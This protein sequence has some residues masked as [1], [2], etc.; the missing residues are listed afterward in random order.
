MAT[1]KFVVG[2]AALVAVIALAPGAPAPGGTLLGVL[3]EEDPAATATRSASNGGPDGSVDAAAIPLAVPA[4]SP[5]TTYQ[6][7]SGV[8][9]QPRTSALTYA[10]AGG[11]ALAV[12]ATASASSLFTLKVELPQGATLTQVIWY[13]TDDNASAS[14][15]MYTS[16][17]LPSD[18]ALTDVTSSFTSFAGASPTRQAITATPASAVV[19]DNTAATYLLQVGLGSTTGMTLWGARV[20][21]TT[22]APSFYP[23]T[24]TRVYDSRFG[25]GALALSQSRTISIANAISLSTGAVTVPNFVPAGARA[26]SYNLTITQTVGFGY[27]Q[28]YPAGG[29]PAASAINWTVPNLDLANGGVLSVSTNRQVTVQAGGGTGSQTHFIIDVTGYFL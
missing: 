23:L 11:G 27:L 7:Y 12:V 26:V 21:F 29:S 2:L 18:D 28:L 8:E 6:T 24:P 10:N 14:A 22:A 25:D 17:Y 20:G 13:V 4:T 5:G 19:V 15:S 3:A 16:R 9:F 1:T